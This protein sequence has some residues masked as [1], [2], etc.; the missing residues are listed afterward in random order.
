MA[1]S[2]GRLRGWTC[3]VSVA[4]ALSFLL[5][6]HERWAAPP[7]SQELD[8]PMRR[9]TVVGSPVAKRIDP[10][11]ERI[12]PVPPREASTWL[13]YRA[14][15]A[16]PLA[17]YVEPSAAVALLAPQAPAAESSLE[18][19]LAERRGSGS[20][21]G[22]GSSAVAGDVRTVASSMSARVSKPET[23]WGSP[24]AVQGP[25]RFAPQTAW[26][27]PRKLLEQMQQLRE[28]LAAARPAVQLTSAR[29]GSELIFSGPGPETSDA[30][31]SA[32]G[33]ARS[34]ELLAW[35]EAVDAQLRRL[36]PSGEPASV[37]DAADALE[38]LKALAD[39]ALER[40]RSDEDYRGEELA[41]RA[42]YALQ[43]RLLL[44]EGVQRCRQESRGADIARMQLST[45]HLV[46]LIDG[47][48]A[49]AVS[50]GD[51]SGWARYLLLGE[52]R[53]AAFDGTLAADD[54][55]AVRRFLDRVTWQMLSGP[56]LDFLASPAVRELADYVQPLAVSPIDYTQLLQDF[57]VLEEQPLHR[58]SATIVS[59]TQ[60]LRYSS[61]PA[62]AALADIIQTHYRNANLRFA[63]AADFI[64]RFLPQTTT[65]VRPVREK[66]LGADT[67][68]GSRVTSR[69]KL[70]LLPEEHAWHLRL[71]LHAEVA[72]LTSSEKGPATV[73]G[74]ANSQVTT[75]RELLIRPEGLSVQKP[76]TDVQTR[77]RI[78]GVETDFDAVPILSDIVHY[79]VDQQVQEQR[80]MARRITR[81]MI[82]RQTDTQFD[83][84]L[85]RHI[86]QARRSLQTQ[87]T[88]PL[89]LIGI[90]SEVVDLQTTQTRLIARHRIATHDSLAAFTPRP[91]A[92]HDAV[93]SVQVHQSAINN[94]CNQFGLSGR[95]W[96][97]D[98]LVQA[99]SG[100]LGAELKFEPEDLPPNVRLRFA[101]DNPIALGFVEGAIELTLRVERLN[102]PG[103]L[104]L[105][106]F[107]IR[108]RYV[109]QVDGLRVRLVR[110]GA[111]SVDGERLSMRDRLPLRAIFGRIFA[112]HETVELTGDRLL[113]DER[114][115]GL[116]VSQLTLCDGWLA[117]ALSAE[118]SPHVAVLRDDSS[119]ESVR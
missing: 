44:W 56:Q 94:A 27:T 42:A 100:R 53:Q 112:G 39:E 103:R 5:T 60:S 37:A 114:L 13:Q 98:E 108:V 80:P 54:S 9:Y 68:G 105:A 75:H 59:A 93:L 106:N 85:G 104:N 51:T 38:R 18:Q 16:A 72:S 69:L 83:Q 45:D 19:R 4:S 70:Q 63:V 67:T 74:A 113:V 92:P 90:D 119:A 116:A 6:Q 107:I 34:G 10:R 102:E 101:E 96:A 66:I 29:V 20:F 33:S 84:E 8:Q 61:D 36:R 87:V 40:P 23:G 43:R 77:D 47:V 35:L 24:L 58:C 99:L 64:D 15:P 3:A 2:N 50:T 12:E 82:A 97:L 1:K 117:V 22:F 52:L 41:A 81:N 11:P 89:Q 62:Q 109:P 46:R 111:I 30:F 78:R 95:D 26:P 25:A 118:Q 7:A 88:E 71:N 73:H 32:G 28:H 48:E 57:E 76:A 49:A 14:R 110:E 17:A 65:D 31:G 91:Q 86:D 79:F 21:A 115:A 55:A